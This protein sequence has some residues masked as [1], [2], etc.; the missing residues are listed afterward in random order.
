M[1]D[2]L[3]VVGTELQWQVTGHTEPRTGM[4]YPFYPDLDGENGKECSCFHASFTPDYVSYEDV[5]E[6]DA[7]YF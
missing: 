1:T 6:T 5:K 7:V 3:H 4:F 2:W